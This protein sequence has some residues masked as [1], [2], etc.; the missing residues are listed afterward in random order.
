M[1]SPV[2]RKICF[3]GSQED[4]RVS[5]LDQTG[6]DSV[7]SHLQE[8]KIWQTVLEY[9][10][11]LCN[12]SS[13]KRSQALNVYI[14]KRVKQKVKDEILPKCKASSL[15]KRLLNIDSLLV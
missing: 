6:C 8:D 14:K 9:Y 15:E 5:S 1:T 3:F 4:T 7:W 12:V 2:D 10:Y 13:D 11:S